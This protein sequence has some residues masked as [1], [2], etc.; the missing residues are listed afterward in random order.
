MWRVSWRGLLAHKARFVL[1]ALAVMLGVMFITATYVITDTTNAGFVRLFTVANAGLDLQVRA[2]Q[3]P[4]VESDGPRDSRSAI[5]EEVLDIVLTTDGVDDAEGILFRAGVAILGSDGEIVQKPGR[6]VF[7]T[8]F[9]DRLELT[10]YRIVEGRGPER[11]GEVLLDANSVKDGKLKIG[12]PVDV[13]FP[14]KAGRQTLTVVGVLGFG[15]EKNFPAAQA[16]MLETSQAQEFFDAEGKFDSVAVAVAPGF[17]SRTV[18]RSLEIVLPPDVEVL[19]G[20]QVTNEQVA[21]LGTFI[22]IFGNV[23]RGFGYV[24]LFVAAFIIVNTFTIVVSQRVRELALLRAL[25]ASPRQIVLAVLAESAVIGA[26]ASAVGLGI[27]YLVGMGIQRLLR[28]VGFDPG[29]TDAVLDVRTVIVGSSIGI[30]VTMV[31]AVWPAIRAA[32]TRPL[33]AVRDVEAVTTVINPTRTLLGLVMLVGGIVALLLGAQSGTSDGLFVAGG[34]ALGMLLG[35][36]VLGPHLARPAAVLLGGPIARIAG[37]NGRLARANVARNPRRTSITA[38]ALMIG[39]AIAMA[40]VVLTASV[41]HSIDTLIDDSIAGDITISD[42]GPGGFTPAIREELRTIPEVASA[43]SIRYG[44]RVALGG[45]GTDI[46]AIEP[47]AVDS[48]LVMNVEEFRS[49]AF[50]AGGVL[51]SK[52]VALDRGWAVGDTIAG[53]FPAQPAASLTIAGLFAT[54]G[55][56]SEAVV[57]IATYDTLYEQRD[58]FFVI[59]SVAAG[60]ELDVALQAVKERVGDRYPNVDVKDREQLKAQQR[61][62]AMLFLA[63]FVGLMLLTLL[64]S[65]L[66]ILNTLALSVIERTR[67]IGLLRAV[68]SHRSQIAWMVVWEAIIVAILGGI[69]GS[70]L[71]I[72]LGIALTRSL[73]DFQITELSIPWVAVAGLI[74]A[75]AIS[76]LVAALYPAWRA[77]RL[78]VLQAIATD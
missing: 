26:V 74:V 63:V 12:G 35:T 43:T 22:G 28:K 49:D 21:E 14:T 15:E 65:I 70:A 8:N 40:V 23:L 73:Q 7:A 38:S 10:P 62:Q 64:I 32:R 48:L 60:T 36:V 44:D 41:I 71:G 11:P 25:G 66:G 76:G 2:V 1:T 59:A 45:H 61:Q 3:P 77:S 31:A 53:S 27:G 67:E 47:Q 13:I 6:P 19:T 34:G 9:V 50:E 54:Q 55:F 51:V 56:L 5:R 4:G 58:D 57:S 30:G 16:A 29:A 68:G 69:L 37:V 20:Q 75:A 18:K 33:A 78:D 39:L 72:V 24:G 46:S 17:E 52:E 42:S